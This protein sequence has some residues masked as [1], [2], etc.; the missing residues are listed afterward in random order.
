M[1]RR[2]LRQ[3]ILQILFQM[4]LAKTESAEA[5]DSLVGEIEMEEK[6][7][8]FIKDR[9][10][11]TYQQLAVIDEKVAKYL[12]KWTLSRLSYIDRSI[13]RLA[14]YEL[15]FTNDTSVKVIVNEAVE[16]AKVFGEEDSPKFINGVLGSLVKE[17]EGISTTL[18]EQE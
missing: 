2:E 9:V 8:S 5:I 15:L 16:L 10:M 11:G 12:K 14:V 18:L 6:D 7:L 3:K 1:K 4:D 17:L 13:L